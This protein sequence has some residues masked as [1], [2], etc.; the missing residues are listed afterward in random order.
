LRNPTTVKTLA[1]Q[2]ITASDEYI[3]MRMVEKE[4]R[5]LIFYFARY[6][7]SK[8]FSYETQGKLNPTIANRIGKRRVLLVELMLKGYQTTLI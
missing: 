1:K 3:G 4:Y 5:E 7:G 6:H 8:F 2:I